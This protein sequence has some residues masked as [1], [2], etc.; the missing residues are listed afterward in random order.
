MAEKNVSVRLVATGGGQVRAELTEIGNAGDKAFDTVGASADSANRKLKVVGDTA[1]RV[2]KSGSDGFRNLGFQV[3]DFA[4]QVGA[5]TSATQAFAQQ[6]PQL[7]SGFGPLGVAIGTAAAVM[8]PLVSALLNA[9]EGVSKFSAAMKKAEGS[10]DALSKAVAAAK[11]PLIEVMK[12]YG[13]SADEVERLNRATLAMTRVSA[14][15]DLR[16][17]AGILGGQAG[18]ADTTRPD[19]PNM[20]ERMLGSVSGVDEQ[21]MVEMSEAQKAQAALADKYRLTTDEATRLSEALRAVGKAGTEDAALQASVALMETMVELAGSTENASNKFGGEGGLWD[22]ASD[23]AEIAKNNVKSLAEEATNLSAAFAGSISQLEQIKRTMDTLAPGSSGLVDRVGGWF[24]SVRDAVNPDQY[25]PAS[26]G[27]LDLIGWAEGTDKGRGY[28]ETLG[29]G[30]YTGGPV[31]LIN[32]TLNEVR[33]LQRQ[34]LA[35]P[36]NSYNSSAVGRYQIV[37]KTL[38]TLMA[39]LNL[40]GDELF[41]EQMQDRLGMEL[42]RGRMGGSQRGWY[43]EW[44]GFEAKGVS[45]AAITGALGVKSVGIDPAVAAARKQ[46]NDELM[47]GL[48]LRA[49]FITSMEQQVA[50]AALE[51]EST[52]RSVYEQTRLRAEMMLTQDAR[53]KGIELTDKI[54]GTERTYGQAISETAAALAASAQEQAAQEDRMKATEDAVKRSGEAMKKLRDDL[55]SGFDSA[56]QS[57]IDGTKSVGDAF[58]DMIANMLAERASAG[59]GSIVDSV[60]GAAFGGF[61]G[62]DALT[63]ALSGAGAPVGGGGFLSRLGGAMAQQAVHVTVGVDQKSGNLTAFTDQR[64]SMGMRQADRSMNQ[65]IATYQRDPL[66]R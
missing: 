41:D 63:S 15:A 62:G 32:M 58:R 55:Q 24:D 16:A 19:G 44:Q 49:N 9:E 13:E 66:K 22:M 34:M 1:Q 26:K 14:L 46:E 47:R 53:A 17:L 36:D 25:G 12:L 45:M 2:G 7:A 60:M 8:V 35:H 51:A 6:F 21:Y 64:V 23:V 57:I 37:G 61:G 33:A 10:S 4:V 5:G 3:Q 65:R 31:N 29:Y 18:S 50:A 30:A 43:D 27:I 56:F 42:V 39:R 48:D 20:L 54:A 11:T 52:G 28:N 38:E 59:F 40:S